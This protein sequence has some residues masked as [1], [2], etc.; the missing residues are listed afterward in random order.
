MKN[1]ILFIVVLFSINNA[2]FS[3][4]ADTTKIVD[5]TLKTTTHGVYAEAMGKNTAYYSIGYEYVINK[6]RNS[7]GII[8]GTALNPSNIPTIRKK[9]LNVY[10]GVSPFY[11]FGKSWGFRV[12]LNLGMAFNPISYTNKLNYVIPPDRP[13]LLKLLPS[14][15]TGAFYRT[16]NYRWQFILSLYSYYLI[17]LQKDYYLHKFWAGEF[18]PIAPALSVKY[19]FKVSQK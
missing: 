17:Y 14:V 2:V 7:F 5:T 3:Q 15:Y 4:K 13:Y 11:E 8:A 19:N 9:N 16:K 1:L 12:G 10:F 18:L 6:K